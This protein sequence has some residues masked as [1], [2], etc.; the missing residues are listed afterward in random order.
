MKAPVRVN[1][2]RRR[3]KYPEKDSRES[4]AR[5]KVPERHVPK[6]HFAGVCSP[7]VPSQWV[8]DEGSESNEETLAYFEAHRNV[9]LAIVALAER[10]SVWPLPPFLWPDL[11]AAVRS[12]YEAQGRRG[13]KEMIVIEPAAEQTPWDLETSVDHCIQPFRIPA[14]RAHRI[15]VFGDRPKIN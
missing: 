1:Q 4:V 12:T 10:V 6:P 5:W 9:S 11:V 14:H 15:N 3:W 8:D 2:L 13:R 7:K